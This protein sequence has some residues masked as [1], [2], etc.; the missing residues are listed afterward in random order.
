MA[1]VAGLTS[2]PT[3]NSCPACWGGRLL[4]QQLHPSLPANIIQE[5]KD[6]RNS[7]PRGRGLSHGF[8]NHPACKQFK[9]FLNHIAKNGRPGTFYIHLSASLTFAAVNIMINFVANKLYS[10]LNFHHMLYSGAIFAPH[11]E[12]H[13][14]L[15]NFGGQFHTENSLFL[16]WWM[17]I[18]VF[19]I[20]PFKWSVKDRPIWYQT[21]EDKMIS[22]IKLQ[23]GLEQIR[24]ISQE[25]VERNSGALKH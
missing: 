25:Q 18:D 16:S 17:L 4:K 7:K 24:N 8:H 9:T 6:S 20:Q 22:S 12:F 13:R 5:W 11:F 1:T 3:Y 2:Q 15:S 14:H 23:L 21:V 19:S 10:F